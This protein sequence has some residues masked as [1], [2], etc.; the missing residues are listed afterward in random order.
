MAFILRMW[1]DA[2][3]Y[4]DFEKGENKLISGIAHTLWHS[5][6]YLSA[7][8]FDGEN[9]FIQIMYARDRIFMHH[10]RSR[11]VKYYYYMLRKVFFPSQN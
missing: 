9:E 5:S 11:L 10:R 3:G 7:M 4:P 1:Y 8:Q 2:G 6:D